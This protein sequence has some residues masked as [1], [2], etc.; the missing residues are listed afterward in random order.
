MWLGKV[1][2]SPTSAC[3]VLGCP[4]CCLACCPIAPF[5]IADPGAQGTAE[6]GAQ[7]AA[8]PAAH[9]SLR[10]C[11]SGAKGWLHPVPSCCHACGPVLPFMIAYQRAADM[12]AP[13]TQGA[14]VPVALPLPSHGRSEGRR[15]SCTMALHP[16]P[17]VL[18]CLLPSPSLHDRIP[19]GPRHGCTQSHLGSRA[20]GPTLPFVIADQRAAGTAE[21]W[22]CTRCP[23]CR[24]PWG[25]GP[26]F[27]ISDQGSTGQPAPLAPGVLHSGS[28]FLRSP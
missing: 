27:T 26:P 5:A 12:A 6:P 1:I 25:L 7:D 3:Q 13:D 18:L 8:V 24:R 23:W 22:G 10:D 21:P 19:G 14:A 15:H 17:R 16:V 20:C 28:L 2:S 9:P 4:G 11:R